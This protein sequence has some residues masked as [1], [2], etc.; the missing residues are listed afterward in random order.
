MPK[1]TN[2]KTGQVF[3]SPKPLSADQLEE[4]FSTAASSRPSSTA[5]PT[6]PIQNQQ[7]Q[8]L[9]DIISTFA[10]N[11]MAGVKTPGGIA[12]GIGQGIATGL[13]LAASLVTGGAS[14]P[15]AAGL[16][17]TGNMLNE[18]IQNALHTQNKPLGEMAKE[19]GEVGAGAGLGQSIGLGLSGLANKTAN[20]LYQSALKPSTVLTP[21]AR[22]ELIETGIKQR[23]PVS[24]RGFDL[25][26]K[27]VQQLT[28][29]GNAAVDAGTKAG[30]KIDLAQVLEPHFNDLE[31]LAPVSESPERYL[32]AVQKYKNDFLA[33]RTATSVSPNDA[34]AIKRD[35]GQKLAPY[36][37]ATKN[38]TAIPSAADIDMNAV[39]SKIYF[40][41]RDELEKQYPILKEVNPDNSTLLRLK[42]QLAKAVGRI[43]NRELISLQDVGAGTIGAAGSQTVG[44]GGIVAVMSKILNNPA[45][46]SYISFAL[47]SASK[48]PNTGGVIGGNAVRASQ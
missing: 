12:S 7:S 30:Q 32:T 15:A 38:A 35:V 4:L 39:R 5:T 20:R 42:S 19:S 48:L 26:E 13:P 16:G 18:A 31:G 40:G 25:L 10:R 34:L 9:G 21:A 2:T 37:N 14:I 24:S 45:V 8:P 28:D 44:G 1:Y 17:F 27:K 43:D 3:N 46:K 6:I 41:L 11:F 36:F 33:G 47:K 22:N 23:I 29:A